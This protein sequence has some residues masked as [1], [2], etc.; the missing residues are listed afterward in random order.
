MNFTSIKTKVSRDSGFGMIAYSEASYVVQMPAS[1]S[2]IH[3]P[4]PLFVDFLVVPQPDPLL[5]VYYA[6]LFTIGGPEY[7]SSAMNH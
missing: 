4:F 6:I 5:L 3:L 1:S 2:F 7:E